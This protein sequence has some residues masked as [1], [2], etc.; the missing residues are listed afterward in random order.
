MYDIDLSR[1]MGDTEA[2][3]QVMSAAFSVEIS[4]TSMYKVYIDA[5]NMKGVKNLASVSNGMCVVLKK[6]A[7]SA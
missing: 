4:F 6:R 1:M 3:T 2:N 5:V 7:V